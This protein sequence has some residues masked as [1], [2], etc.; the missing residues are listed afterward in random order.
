[1][2]TAH[3]ACRHVKIFTNLLTVLPILTRCYCTAVFLQI[4]IRYGKSIFHS[5]KKYKQNNKNNRQIYNKGMKYFNSTVFFKK[6]SAR[7]PEGHVLY[8]A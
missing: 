2:H 7:I 1:M 3:Y 8:G 4:T 5:H 6:I